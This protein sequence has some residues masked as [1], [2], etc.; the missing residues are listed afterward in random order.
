MTREQQMTKEKRIKEFLLILLAFAVVSAVFFFEKRMNAQNTTAMALSYQYGLIPRGLVGTLL[1]LLKEFF[2]ISLYSY[3]RI[4]C[5]TALVTVCYYGIL[6]AFYALCLR[7]TKEEHMKLSE[8]VIVFLSIFMFTE[9]LTWN[10]FGR[11]DEYLMMITLLCLILL[12]WEKGEWLLIPLCAAAGLVHV[13][14]VFT[15]VGVILVILLWKIFQREGRERKKYMILFAG[16][17][18]CVSILFLYF[19]MFRQ[20]LGRNEYEE[21]VALARSVSEDGVSISD[22]LLDS[23]ILGLDVFEDEWVWH[24]KNYVET[25]IF[26]LLFSPYLFIAVRFFRNLIKNAQNAADRWNYLIVLLGAGTI[27]PELILK[28]DYGRWMF[29]IIAYYCLVVLALIALGDSYLI[30]QLKHTGRWLKEKC[31]FYWVLLIYPIIFV[32]FR[33]VYI[34]DVTTRIMDFVAPILHIW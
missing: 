1:Y 10:N 12:V 23:E 6:F 25:P 13:G 34:S 15:N 32:P 21:I 29:C 31:S 2:G 17:F 8:C 14:F 16:C 5:F 19:E 30:G 9:F 7:K 20:P 26:L 27:V 22:S 3:R 11:L 18:L 33:D 4:L 28:V 24:T